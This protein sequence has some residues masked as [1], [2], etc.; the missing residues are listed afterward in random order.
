MKIGGNIKKKFL[1]FVVIVI[2]GFPYKPLFSPDLLTE[3]EKVK[4]GLATKR[5]IKGHHTAYLMTTIGHFSPHVSQFI[6]HS[7]ETG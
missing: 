6:L 1:L 2:V 7:V 3:W 5:P 4:L